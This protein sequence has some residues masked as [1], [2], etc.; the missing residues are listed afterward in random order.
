MDSVLAYNIVLGPMGTIVQLF[1]LSLHGSVIDVSLAVTAYSAV[2][3]PAA[4]LWGFITDRFNKRKTLIIVSYFVS[5]VVLFSFLFAKTV[6]SVSFLYA[7]FSFATSASTTPLNLLVMETERKQKWA[8]AFARLSMIA[9]FGQIVGLFLSMTWSLFF[10]LGYIVVVLSALSLVS[11]V[12]SVLL[13]REPAIVF[14]RDVIAMNKPSFFERLKT[15]PYFFLRIPRAKDFR[16]FFKTLRYDLTRQ[17]PLLYFSIFG[18]YLTSGLFNTSVVPSLEANGVPTLLIFLVTTV[19]MVVQVV[20]FKYAGPYIEKLSLVRAAVGGLGLRSI[21]YGLLGVSVFLVSGIWLLVPFLI[22]Y[23]LAGGIAYAIYYTAS[24]T[25]VF[26]TLRHTNQGSRLG[27]YSALVGIATMAGSF[28]SG[29][30]SFYLGFYTTFILAAIG[31]A[32]SAWAISKLPS[33]EN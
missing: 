18:F 25:M 27:I 32:I 19:V 9:S 2:N 33:E 21:T 29:F 26:N 10:P 31:L 7:L 28:I 4:I 13:I 23:P 24:N 14:E 16:R 30:T 11:A 6:Y 3:I 5:G 1:I 22:F 17:V 12:L 20:S 8:M 15:V